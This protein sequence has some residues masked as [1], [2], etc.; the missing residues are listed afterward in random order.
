MPVAI[1]DLEWTCQPQDTHINQV[2][3]PAKR[4]GKLG[5]RQRTAEQ[6]ASRLAS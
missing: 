2:M 4:C 3:L 5:L 6:A 1:G